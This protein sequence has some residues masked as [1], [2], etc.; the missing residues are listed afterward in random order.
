MGNSKC[1]LL[2]TTPALLPP[3]PP[4]SNGK[5]EN[6]PSLVSNRLF[7]ILTCYSAMD[8]IK[9][10]EYFKTD[11]HTQLESCLFLEKCPCHSL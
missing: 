5:L 2:P 4:P 8:Y 11:T 1:S 6:F 9:Y 3:P 10:Q 7:T